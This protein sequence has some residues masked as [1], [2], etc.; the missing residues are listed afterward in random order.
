[1]F[2]LI[3]EWIEIKCQ[4]WRWTFKCCAADWE[5]HSQECS[6]QGTEKQKVKIGWCCHSFDFLCLFLSNHQLQK[7]GL[8][9]MQLWKW[10][11]KLYW[12]TVSK[13]TRKKL[14]CLA[15]ADFLL[16][17]IN[18]PKI[19]MLGGLKS[20]RDAEYGATNSPP[21]RFYIY[22]YEICQVRSTCQ[23][24]SSLLIWGLVCWLKF[25]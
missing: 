18:E 16:N 13:R 17:E 10:S 11:H 25:S 15:K 20:Q 9:D 7:R 22:L 4:C 19:K 23:E 3:S 21:L 5:Q 24:T 6:T 8:W 12:L 2:F 1:M 14:I